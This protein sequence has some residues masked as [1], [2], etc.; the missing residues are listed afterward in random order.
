MAFKTKS[1]FDN[2]GAG[3][4]SFGFSLLAELGNIE[5]F[6]FDINRTILKKIGWCQS[7]KLIEST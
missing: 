7:Y 2:V 3:F 1:F 4:I 6:I 5:E